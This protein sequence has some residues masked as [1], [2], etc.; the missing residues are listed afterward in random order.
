M[1]L[2]GSQWVLF[3]TPSYGR[4]ERRNDLELEIVLVAVAVGAALK[5]ANL[6]VEP[7]NQAEAD[8]VLGV[9]VGSNAI[10]VALDHRG[11][12]LVG[13]EPLPLQALL[14]AFEEGPRPALGL[15]APELAE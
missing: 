14:P 1:G 7:L 6:V 8:L 10:P 5:H 11:E 12:V 4:E 13:R 2:R 15:V 9:A 3:R